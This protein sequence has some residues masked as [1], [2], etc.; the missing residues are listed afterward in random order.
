MASEPLVTHNAVDM[1]HW[2]HGW[3]PVSDGP[4][5]FILVQVQREKLP[6]QLA[7]WRKPEDLDPREGNLGSEPIYCQLRRK[8]DDSHSAYGYLGRYNRT[9]NYE[10]FVGLNTHGSINRFSSTEY[11]QRTFLHELVQKLRRSRYGL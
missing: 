2:L 3:A 11:D 10:G 5:Y 7:L 8:H 9:L 1:Y 4:T 6:F